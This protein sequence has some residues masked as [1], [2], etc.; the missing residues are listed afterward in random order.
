[1]NQQL[2]AFGVELGLSVTIKK[3]TLR[4]K[5]RLIGQVGSGDRKKDTAD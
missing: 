2:I 1:M 4:C 3:R 5:V